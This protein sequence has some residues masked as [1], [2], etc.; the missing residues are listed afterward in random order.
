MPTRPLR[1][2]ASSIVTAALAASAI[3]ASTIVV[4]PA[5]AAQVVPYSAEAA[6]R[7]TAQSRPLIYH[8]ITTWCTICAAQ[9]AVMK[10]LLGEPEFADYTVL[11]IDLE[12][13]PQA[14]AALGVTERS[15]LIAADGAKERA[16]ATGIIEPAQI[17]AL[18][19]AAKTGS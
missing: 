4:L 11:R 12:K 8:V 6:Q 1:R 16:R 2:L 10:T 3:A 19:Q 9:T 13:Q 15:T 18:L 17:R 14:A 5:Q 7:A